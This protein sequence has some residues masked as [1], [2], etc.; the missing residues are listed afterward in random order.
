MRLIRTAILVIGLCASTA[1]GQTAPAQGAQPLAKVPAADEII[2]RF[3]EAIGGRKTL[4]T[5]NSRHAV[6]T[7]EIPAQGLKGTL[8]S[9]AARPNKQIVRIDLPGVGQILGGFDGTVGWS[10][11]PAVGP[12]LMEGGHLEQ[13]RMQADFDHP[14]HDRK[15][16]K[17]IETVEQM[18]FEGMNAWK[19]R[20]VTTGGIE[21]FEYF[22][23]RTGLLLGSTGAQESP[24][25]A[26]P[27]TTVL[28]DYKAF[29]GVRLPTRSVQR[30]SGRE[31]V[32]TIA[33]V[34]LNTVDP[35]VFELP[36]QIKALIK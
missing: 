24:T 25:G 28:G 15:Y 6:G 9:F 29:G 2:E 23:V 18:T 35:A 22:D 11:N 31:L 32:A 33:S 19:V 5:V 27:V 20:V 1:V 12:T 7:F 21:S 34:E 13:A 10:I 16:F 3:V 17:A 8:E 4:E 30:A 26:I 36:A 14:L